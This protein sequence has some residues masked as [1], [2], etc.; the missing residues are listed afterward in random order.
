MSGTN[1]LMAQ[2]GE[3]PTSDD[4]PKPKYAG[5]QKTQSLQDIT[6]EEA[7]KLFD[8]PRE[9]GEF[10][11][12]PVTVAIGRFGPYC[13]HD[14]KFVSLGKDND[15]YTVS[16]ETCI[17]LIKEKRKQ[18]KEKYIHQFTDHDPPIEVLNGRYGPYITM[19]KKNYKIPKDVDPKKLTVASCLDIINA[20]KP[21]K[22]TRKKSKKS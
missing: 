6:L 19:D 5:L 4:D 9:A 14:G 22:K 10:E 1:G 17:E 13:K 3:T 2:I 7:L 18:E 16:L 21:A 20:P 11:E 12:L 15:P 8:L